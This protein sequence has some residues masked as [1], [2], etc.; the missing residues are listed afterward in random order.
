MTLK[1]CAAASAVVLVAACAPRGPVLDTTPRP[2]DVGGTIAGAVLAGGGTTPLAGRTVTAVN[3][4]SGARFDTS[5]G[6]NGGY[7]VKVPAGTYRLEVELRN[8][9]AIEKRPQATE[10]NVGDLDPDRDFVLTVKP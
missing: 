5:S 10:V 1:L 9:E 3:E 6:T 2:D 7:T 8:G 4:A